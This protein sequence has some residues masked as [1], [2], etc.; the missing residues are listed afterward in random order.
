MRSVNPIQCV[1][2]PCQLRLV[3]SPIIPSSFYVFFFD[4]IHIF[5]FESLKFLLLHNHKLRVGKF[6]T[7]LIELLRS[8]QHV[9]SKFF[10]IKKQNKNVQFFYHFQINAVHHVFVKN[11]SLVQSKKILFLK[12]SIWVPNSE[13]KSVKIVKIGSKLIKLKAKNGLFKWKFVR[14]LQT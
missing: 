9:S 8:S 2:E 11:K 12:L 4:K 6:G 1:V 7:F 10:L 3:N 5:P 13:F 14:V